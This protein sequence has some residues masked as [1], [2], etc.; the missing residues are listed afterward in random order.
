MLQ[1]LGV[2]LDGNRRWAREHGLD[3]VSEGHRIGFGK[4]P[5][6]L[7]WCDELRIP[8]VTIWMLSDD[9]IA[10]RPPAELAELYAIDVRVVERLRAE[11]RWRLHHI[12]RTELLPEKLVKTL[13]DAEHSTAA[14]SAML[15]NLAIGYG[16]R[17]DVVGAIRSMMADAADG[18]AVL[19][20]E[21]EIS[22]RLSTSGQPD[23]D[24]VIRP[25][26]V[27]RTSGFMIWQAA[28]AELYFCDR[29]WPDFT[30]AD[31]LHAVSSYERRARR[32]GA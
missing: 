16:G 7:S 21:D 22:R 29:L 6:L 10:Q 19:P 24:L 27:S 20:T 30:R 18:R 28:L 2:V 11:G 25:S 15:V 23:P 13:R 9:N 3:P 31:L 12:G 17:S 4:I 1:H 8:V 32:L 14:H 26:G 5:E